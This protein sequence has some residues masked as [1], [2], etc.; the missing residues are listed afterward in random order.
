MYIIVIML[1]KWLPPKLAGS[2]RQGF[3]QRRLVRA[4]LRSYI[5]IY[6]YIYTRPPQETVVCQQKHMS[7]NI[8]S[9]YNVIYYFR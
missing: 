1:D 3:L 7:T 8:S 5:Y 2:G 9:I 6:I 4:L